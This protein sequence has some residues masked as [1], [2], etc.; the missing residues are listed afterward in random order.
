MQVRDG[1]AAVTGDKFRHK[2]L[3]DMTGRR[4]ARVNRKSEDLP[5]WFG[6][7]PRTG[8]SADDLA[9]NREIPGSIVYRSGDF[10]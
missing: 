4:G 9:D 5:E 6:Q 10:F 2:P 7:T 3:S 8:F 1:P